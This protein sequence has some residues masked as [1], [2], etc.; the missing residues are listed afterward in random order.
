M[1]SKDDEQDAREGIEKGVANNEPATRCA[2]GGAL[3]VIK[4]IK[5]IPV[6]RE[7]EYATG[8]VIVFSRID[9]CLGAI[10]IV[11]DNSLC[12]AHFSMYADNV[13]QWCPSNFSKAMAAA[14][15]NPKKEIW[16]FGGGVSDWERGLGHSIWWKVQKRIFCGLISWSVDG[17]YLLPFR[18]E[19][20]K[21]WIFK[22]NG[23]DQRG[24][25][26]RAMT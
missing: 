12:G 22:L 1:V 15:F 24:L 5:G 21:K 25:T 23:S 13:S 16:Y 14:G 20:Q 11:G 2:A 8:P 18:D 10:Q 3:A 26:Y 17:H 4:T 7:W 6:I 19:A 9:S